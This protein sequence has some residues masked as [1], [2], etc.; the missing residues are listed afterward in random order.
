MITWVEKSMDDD[1]D[2][3]T[4]LAI[5]F[6]YPLFWFLFFKY[7]LLWPQTEEA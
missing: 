6:K 3:N 5:I 2:S 4:T 1:M 7:R